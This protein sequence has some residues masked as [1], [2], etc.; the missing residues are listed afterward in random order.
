MRAENDKD[1]SGLESLTEEELE[2][3]FATKNVPKNKIEED[4]I[5]LLIDTSQEFLNESQNDYK[6]NACAIMEEIKGQDDKREKEMLDRGIL[7]KMEDNLFVFASE[8][9]GMEQIDKETIARTI[10]EA[11]KSSEYYKRKKERLEIVKQRVKEKKKLLSES[12]ANYSSNKVKAEELLE[13]YRKEYD[14]TRTWIHVDMDMFYAAIEIRND[15]SLADKPIA[16]GSYSMIA[17]ANYVARKYGVRSAMPGFIGRKL[18]P[19]LITIQYSRARHEEYAR[20]SDEIMKILEEYNPELEVIGLDEAALD[21]TDYL[22]AKGNVN[23]DTRLHLAQE[24]QRRIYEKVKLTASCGVAANKMLAKIS[25]DMKKPNGITLVPFNSKEIE[26]FMRKLSV[27]KI[28][29]VGAVNEQLL[30]GL[31]FNT[32]EDILKRITDIYILFPK[33]YFEFY[34][35]SSLGISRNR[36]V[37]KAGIHK[38]V[39]ISSTFKEITL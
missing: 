15:P 7:K 8:K 35:K 2:L 26:E 24:I 22:E 1:N 17:T 29:G 34:V 36:H 13:K 31:G 32:C 39:G 27:R 20:V 28:P 12:T 21:V 14:L 5:D 19:D 16:V 30:N 6:E 38:S 25:C 18:C 37:E 9:A 3:L 33:D 11:S 4:I 23:N 10:E